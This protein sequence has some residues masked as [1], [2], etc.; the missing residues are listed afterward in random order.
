MY[1]VVNGRK[2]AVEENVETIIIIVIISSFI[3]C[4]IQVAEEGRMLHF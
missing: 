1:K 4:H 2:G 3:I